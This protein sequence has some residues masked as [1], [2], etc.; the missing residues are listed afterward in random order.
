MRLRPATPAD[1]SFIRSLTCDPAYAPF[2]GDDDE[3]QLARY[4]ADP[5]ARLLIWEDTAPLGFA[6]FREI[7][8]ASGRVELFRLALSGAGKGGGAAFMTT[9]I[10]FAF[11]EL[12]AKRLWLDASSENLRAQKLYE[13]VGFTL[14]GQLR[15]HWY[16]PALGYA[17]DLML[18]GLMRD[19]WCNAKA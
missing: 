11:G 13:R 12:Q 2:I 19:K 16:R 3:A 17:V 15:Q 7:G 18:Y 14:E 9:L 5:A 6:I 8:E 1:F 4:L 10:D